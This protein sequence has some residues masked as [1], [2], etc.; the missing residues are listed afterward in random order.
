MT[1]LTVPTA[2]ADVIQMTWS[3]ETCDT[4][5]TEEPIRTLVEPDTKPFPFIVR[6]V[7]PFRLPTDGEMSFIK[8]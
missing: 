8:A 1:K 6:T 7:P 2:C 5:Q 3:N 4:T